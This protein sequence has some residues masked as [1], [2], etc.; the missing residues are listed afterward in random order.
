MDLLFVD[1]VVPSHV[2]AKVIS[3][4][5]RFLAL[6]VWDNN[7]LQMVCLDMI[8]NGISGAFLPAYS[9]HVTLPTSV[10]TRIVV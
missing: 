1:Q 7:S 6:V 9:A 5:E 2:L 10:A 8:L 4:S 3:V